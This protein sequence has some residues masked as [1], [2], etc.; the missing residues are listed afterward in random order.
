ML[1]EAKINIKVQPDTSG[2]EVLGI[3]NKVLR[4]KIAAPPEKGKANKK[5]VDFL[6]Q[7]LDVAKADISIVRGHTSRQKV[8]AIKGLG[9]Q[10]IMKR[11]LPQINLP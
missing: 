3:R 6:S 10:E 8:V 9:Q 2:N 4:I 5:L 11:L 7:R 1:E